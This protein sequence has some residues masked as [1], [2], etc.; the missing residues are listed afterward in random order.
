MKQKKKHLLNLT[1]TDNQELIPGFF[2][3]KA[4]DRNALLPDIHPGHFAEMKLS[5]NET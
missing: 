3:I 2:R 4:T 5:G 1:I